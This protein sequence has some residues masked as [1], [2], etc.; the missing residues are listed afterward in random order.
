DLLEQFKEDRSALKLNKHN[1]IARS[2]AR[3]NSIKRGQKLDEKGMRH[4]TDQL[5]ACTTPYVSPFG[6]L[7]FTSFS[8]EE[9]AKQ[10]QKNN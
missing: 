7:T 1:V 3:T 2:M 6:N 10:F 9:L 5:F 8:L 4:L